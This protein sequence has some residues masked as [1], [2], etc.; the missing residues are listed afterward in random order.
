MWI[1][2]QLAENN[3][4][5]NFLTTQSITK[6]Q[7]S[8]LNKNVGDGKQFKVANINNSNKSACFLVEKLLIG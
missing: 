1:R 6:P 2:K 4:I 5:I 7:D 3:F 8:S